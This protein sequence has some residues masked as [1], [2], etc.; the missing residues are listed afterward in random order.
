MIRNTRANAD[1]DMPPRRAETILFEA[2][3]EETRFWEN[4][5]NELRSR[6]TRI[7]KAEAAMRGRILL[8]AAGSSP[9]AWRE[10]AT[11]TRDLFDGADWLC[12]SSPE[13]SWKT[14]FR[15]LRALAS[16]SGGVV[17]FTQFR[18]TQLALA[19]ALAEESV[20][21]F[22]ING[23]V[24]SRKRNEI[25]EAFRLKGGALVSTRA[26]SEGTNLQFCHQIVNFDL[27]WNPMEIEQRIGRLHRMGQKQRVDIFNFIRAKSLQEHLLTLLV[28]KLNL[29]ELTI[30]ETGLILGERY[31]AEEFSEAILEGWQQGDDGL[32]LNLTELGEE[33]VAART[34]HNE[35]QET[36]RSLF[37]RDFE[38]L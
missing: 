13:R 11:R 8:Q 25:V 20:P 16:S 28:E 35:I 29:F 33:L 31:S 38:M 6:L 23:S 30:G 37:A 22:A 1:I 32:S 36:D 3:E 24:P 14:K 12:D 34:R 19:K 21:V 26:G 18:L 2:D 15:P 17:V 4:W 7:P 27:P 10:A 5:E 9:A